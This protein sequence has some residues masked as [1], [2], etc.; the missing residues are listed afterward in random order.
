MLFSYSSMY[1][2]VGSSPSIFCIA[3]FEKNVIKVIVIMQWNFLEEM[4]LQKDQNEQMNI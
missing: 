1:S 2:T 3:N 4:W